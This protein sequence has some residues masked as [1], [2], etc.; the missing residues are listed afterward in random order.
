MARDH[1]RLDPQGADECPGGRAPIS[2]A[3][4][5][6]F[7]VR[8]TAYQGCAQQA[9]YGARVSAAAFLTCW[10]AL[11]DHDRCQ[12]EFTCAPFSSV[13][14]SPTRLSRGTSGTPSCARAS[15]TV[16]IGLPSRNQ[17]MWSLPTSTA[18]LNG[19]SAR[20]TSDSVLRQ[21]ASALRDRTPN[22]IPGAPMVNSAR[23]TL[24]AEQPLTAAPAGTSSRRNL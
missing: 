22:R 15:V 3:G 13:P 18:T 7:P 1:R 23:T 6:S 14:V 20:R 2:T 9:E 5:A 17:V 24:S 21:T 4:P 16:P 12:S 8:G 11:S 19:C 10:P